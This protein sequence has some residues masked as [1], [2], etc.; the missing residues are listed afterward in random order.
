M[1]VE[2]QVILFEL[3]NSDGLRTA[4][5]V[6]VLIFLCNLDT[7]TG[8]CFPVPCFFTTSSTRTRFRGLVVFWWPQGGQYAEDL[9]NHWQLVRLT[10]SISITSAGC[11]PAFRCLVK[12]CYTTNQTHYD[13][14]NC[15]GIEEYLFR[16]LRLLPSHTRITKV[17]N[18][19]EGA[20]NSSALED[21][22][23]CRWCRCCGGC[24]R[25]GWYCHLTTSYK[26]QNYE[27]DEY[28]TV[29]WNPYSTRVP[30]R[31]RRSPR[32]EELQLGCQLT[33]ASSS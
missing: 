19:R 3:W 8:E 29:A 27:C 6:L 22:A 5:H 26:L 1:L 10:K 13:H 30:A 23:G 17:K 21:S 25:R 24:W 12:G 32:T 28:D 11:R 31:D 16:I 7:P 20:L 2:I 4:T 33:L 18:R 9:L 14:R 15:Y